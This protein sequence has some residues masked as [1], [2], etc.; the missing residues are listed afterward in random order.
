MPGNQRVP[1]RCLNLV[2]HALDLIYYGRVLNV[3]EHIHFERH[4]CLQD[5][6]MLVQR[7]VVKQ[8]YYALVTGPR[9]SSE[10]E[11]GVEDELLEDHSVYASFHDLCGF[12]LRLGNSGNQ[13]A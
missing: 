5:L 2:E 9:V 6:F 13:C 8:Q 3:E 11:Q 10:L 4:R 12:H 7:D 1:V